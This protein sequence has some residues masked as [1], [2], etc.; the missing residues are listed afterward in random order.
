MK[1]II[2][3]TWLNR[4]DPLI[5][6]THQQVDADAAFS[7]ALLRVIKPN[8]AIV[9]V[10]ADSTI[11]QPEVIAVDLMNGIK[12]CEGPWAL[13]VHSDSSYPH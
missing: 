4:D 1:A 9:F 3:Q 10:R 5:I 12:C 6:A 13:E 8:A 11:S 2:L 7:A